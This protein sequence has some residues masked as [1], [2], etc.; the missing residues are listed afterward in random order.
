M[1]TVNGALPSITEGGKGNKIT[2]AKTVNAVAGTDK[3]VTVSLP[4]TL[5]GKAVTPDKTDYGFFTLGEGKPDSKGKKVSF[6]ITPKDAG[7]AYIVWTVTDDSKNKIQ[8]V[9]KVLVKKPV[10]KTL[11]INHMKEGIDLEAGEGNRI[12]VINTPENTESKDLT[13]SVKMTSGKGI[14]CSKSGFIIASS[15]D[16]AVAVVTVKS[17]KIKKEINVRCAGRTDN[18][19]ALKQTS[20]NVKK[21][22]LGGKDKAVAFKAAL[23]KKNPPAFKLSVAG[24]PKGIIPGTDCKINVTAD[25]SPGCYM[26][27]ATPEDKAFNAYSCELIVK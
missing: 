5:Q 25:A 11:S 17:G 21:P 1:I 9:T 6:T 19:F 13:F 24:D 8:A 12:I 10:D 23:P 2:A 4:K 20:V 14:T 3:T 15:P 16:K 7:A 27:I 26:V 22:K 18:L